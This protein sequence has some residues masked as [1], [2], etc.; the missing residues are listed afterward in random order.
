M[1]KLRLLSLLYLASLKSS[2]DSSEKLFCKKVDSR[3]GSMVDTNV[4]RA[5]VSKLINS[6]CKKL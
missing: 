4:E 2:G 3:A 6:L 5:N 1:E